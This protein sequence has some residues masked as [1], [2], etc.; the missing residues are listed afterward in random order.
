MTPAERRAT[1]RGPDGQSPRSAVTAVA[2]PMTV[3]IRPPARHKCS[4]G[5]FRTSVRARCTPSLRVPSTPPKM[6]APNRFSAVWRQ[7]RRGP[8]SSKEFLRRRVRESP[9]QPLFVHWCP[10][11]ELAGHKRNMQ[12]PALCM[13]PPRGGSVTRPRHRARHP[14]TAS[15]SPW[16]IRAIAL[17]AADSRA[18]PMPAERRRHRRLLLPKVLASAPPRPARSARPGQPGSAAT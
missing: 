3:D 16:R 14:R 18:F 8:V 9:G 17:H 12:W 1:F 10:P 2:A 13:R 4:L 6:L 15:L 7:R 11:P 5:R